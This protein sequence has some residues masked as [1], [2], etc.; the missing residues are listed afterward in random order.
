MPKSTAPADLDAYDVAYAVQSQDRI[1]PDLRSW[2]P[3]LSRAE[4]ETEASRRASIGLAGVTIITK[5]YPRR[6]NN[7]KPSHVVREPFA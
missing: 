4:A 5:Y 1:F 3:V 7:P 6:F 2:V